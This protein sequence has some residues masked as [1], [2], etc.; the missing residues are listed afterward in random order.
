MR[1]IVASDT[2]KFAYEL[3]HVSAS[4]FNDYFCETDNEKEL[5]LGMANPFKMFIKINDFAWVLKENIIPIHKI[6]RDDK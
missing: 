5:K 1:A 3:F 4:H 6:M 2:K